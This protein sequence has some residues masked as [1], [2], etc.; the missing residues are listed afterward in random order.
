MARSSFTIQHRR[1][2]YPYFFRFFLIL[3]KRCFAWHYEGRTSQSVYKDSTI[4][5]DTGRITHNYILFKHAYFTRTNVYQKNFFFS[6]FEILTNIVSAIRRSILFA[7]PAAIIVPIIFLIIDSNLGGTIALWVFLTY[8]IA[9]GASAVFMVSGFIIRK[10]LKLDE[11]TD[12]YLVANGYEEWSTRA[13]GEHF[14]P[15][16]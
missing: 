13:E 2:R 7:L 15:D 4:N 14:D 3:E 9:Y 8:L 11:K 1:I 6:L 12:N 10:A 16:F 5:Y